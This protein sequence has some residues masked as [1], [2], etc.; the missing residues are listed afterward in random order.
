MAILLGCQQVVYQL[1]TPRESLAKNSLSLPRVLE[2][3]KEE[4]SKQNAIRSH[5]RASLKFD[6]SNALM[7]VS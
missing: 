3:M 1:A 2:V 5:L 4:F 6:T 7:R